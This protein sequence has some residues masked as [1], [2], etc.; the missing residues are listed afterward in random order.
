MKYA[1]TAFS[2]HRRLL[3]AVLPAVFAAI[4][5][6]S[7]ASAEDWPARMKDMH[8]GGISSEKLS[9]PLECVWKHTTK[10]APAPA[11]IESP[12]RHD[13][14][15]RHYNLKPRQHFDRCFDVAVVDGRV[16]FGSSTSG[17]VTCLDANNGGKTLWTFFTGGPVRFAPHVAGGRVYFGSDDGYVYCLKADDASEI[18]KH[19][20][21][22]SNEKIWGNEHMISVWP[23]RTSVLVDGDEVYFTAGLFPN[24]GMYLCKRNANDG[25]EIWTKTPVRP[26][27]G[28]LAAT[29]DLL[30]APSGKSTTAVYRRADG[31]SLGDLAK[32][33]R[34]G[35][36]WTLVTP[37]EEQAVAGPTL[38]G[39]AQQFG[40]P[41]REFIA[42]LGGVNR[43]IADG[44]HSFCTTDDKILALARKDRV[45]VWT[46]DA[47]YP[48]ALI[49]AGDHLF[50]G[51]AGKVAAL[52]AKTGEPLWEAA[53]DGN[54]YGLAA[55]GGALYASTDAGTIY[56]FRPQS[57]N[58]KSTARR[59]AT[60]G[61]RVLL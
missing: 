15:H 21:G 22:P 18:W 33:S 57:P 17:A 32:S 28:Y 41:K 11:W 38:S 23:V 13:Y 4:L 9:L 50:A 43:L 5:V 51:G 16:Y 55:A 47:A 27:Q 29:K 12:A 58:T 61:N 35:G 25:S 36:C 1:R 40:V 48:Y 6:A 2:S 31:K 30:F 49:K 24:E 8:R 42:V 44:T 26:H 37:D 53:A 54:V 3:F 39:D 10:R 56:C 20:V 19:R 52:D 46:R 14:L 45:P 34:D 60:R 59:C 7:G